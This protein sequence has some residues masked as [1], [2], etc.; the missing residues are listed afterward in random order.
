MPPDPL[1]PSLQHITPKRMSLYKYTKAN[2]GYLR[3]TRSSLVRS[4]QEDKVAPRL[5]QVPKVLIV[6]EGVDE[7]LKM[8]VKMG[9]T[10][11]HAMLL[12]VV[13]F[14]I[15]NHVANAKDRSCSSGQRSTY[16][17]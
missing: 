1:A 2:V 17:F 6:A 16:A 7:A 5:A 12:L 10:K 8:L 4:A 15:A 13:T 3:I 11:R 9:K 14:I